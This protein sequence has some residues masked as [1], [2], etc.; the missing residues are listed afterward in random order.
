MLLNNKIVASYKLQEASGKKI[1]DKG[2]RKKVGI[3]CE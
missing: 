3:V 2:K 1:K